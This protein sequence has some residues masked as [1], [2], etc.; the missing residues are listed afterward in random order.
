MLS[1]GCA[2]KETHW[3]T[4]VLIPIVTSEMGVDDIFGAEY[5]VSN[6]DQSV[7][8]VV[9][10]YIDMLNMD[11]IVEVDDTIAVDIFSVPQIFT[12]PPGQKV[13]QKEAVSKV[14]F[15]ALELTKSRAKRAKLKFYVSNYVKQPL[16]VKYELYS[17]TKDGVIFEVEEQVD[18]ATGG[19]A[20]TVIKEIILDDYD[21]DLRGPNNDAYNTLYAQTTVW[22]HPDAD[23]AIVAPEDTIMIVSVFDEF[24]PEY[25][26]GYLGTQNISSTSSSSIHTFGNFVSGS[27]DLNNAK[28]TLDL[29][30]FLGVDMTLIFNKLSSKNNSTNTEISLNHPIIGSSLN[31]QRGSESGMEDYPVYSKHYKYD[32]TNSNLD[33]MIEIQPD[34]LL[35]SV[36]GII[37]PLGNISAGN[38]FIYFDKGLEAKVS[39]EIPLNFS[40]NNLVIRDKAKIYID[41]D[42][43]KGGYL[44]IYLKN[45]FPFDLDMQMYILD[46][47]DAIIDSLF[48][49]NTFI[50]GAEVDGSG[51]VSTI[52]KSEIRIKLTEEL[53]RTLQN[54]SN[55]LIKA[56]LNSIENKQYKLYEHY[57]LDIKVVGDFVYEI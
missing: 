22:I 35:I 32:I 31:L 38:D 3:Q 1:I 4:D 8:V 15:G 9:E 11:S 53:L 57:N 26:F 47:Q 12:I 40:A 39:L 17:A 21:L 42:G 36:S 23:T 20:T 18:A 37:N 10:E 48:K 43:I 49:D 44:N 16:L 29:Y 19:V 41:D 2:K 46:S 25:A 52:L 7:S 34:S 56:R 55:M 6:P 51:V 30:N 24:V 54:N 27:F 5:I 28:A 45:G 33:E 14:N 13:I 50:I